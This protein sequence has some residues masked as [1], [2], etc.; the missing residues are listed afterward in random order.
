MAPPAS[1]ISVN[2]IFND[3]ETK[4]ATVQ[5]VRET[6]AQTEYSWSSYAAVGDKIT[7]KPVDATSAAIEGGSAG[8]LFYPPTRAFTLDT[9]KCPPPIP[10][11]IAKPGLFVKGKITPAL[12]G[13]R[14]SLMSK[15]GN[16]PLAATV[17]SADGT[18]AVGP[19]YDDTHYSIVVD[20]EGYT[21]SAVPNSAE[22]FKA[23]KLAFL[24]ATVVEKRK[25]KKNA[26]AEATDSSEPAALEPVGLGGVLLSL[27]GSGYRNNNFTNPES[28]TLVFP[29]L[30]PGDYFLRPLLKEYVFTPASQS[31]KIS[32]G[33]EKTVTIEGRR[34]AYS[35]YGR[36][37]ALNGD[38]EKN[39][40]VRVTSAPGATP[41][42]SDEANTDATG[43]FRVRGLQ[44]GASY[45]VD[46]P[47]VGSDHQ[48]TANGIDRALPS[49]HTVTVTDGDDVTGV[50]FLVFRR[51][52]KALLT[53]HVVVT[54]TVTPHTSPQH[55]QYTPAV[56]L[57]QLWVELYNKADRDTAIARVGL[58][59]S[60]FFDFGWLPADE[61][62]VRVA[63]SLS[64]RQYAF[65]PVE[66]TFSL[67]QPNT[68][69]Q[70]NTQA[71]P[72]HHV[73]LHFI[74]SPPVSTNAAHAQE[75]GPNTSIFSLAIAVVLVLL[76][77]NYKLV[78]EKLSSRN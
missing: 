43:S 40:A 15:P 54:T 50:E 47:L 68:Q 72:S 74:T 34:V 76:A 4:A 77:L 5:L 12:A 58:G 24:K 14:V 23:R 28:G 18:Y 63:A 42:F 16:N 36:V 7:V 69:Q 62:R 1:N 60:G 17:T 57:P 45:V 35:L 6:G 53:G 33:E 46:L 38:P 71:V 8:L 52:T 66:A 64:R 32:E 41:A 61:Y 55:A 37:R 9:P 39:V 11:I 21:F 78:L 29:S 10:A 49:N 56:V 51:P 65:A 22:D 3:E 59:P 30:E 48:V 70:Q 13:A 25:V 20:K 19:L 26:D 27:S 44:P 75:A 67:S 31:I 73:V 2:L